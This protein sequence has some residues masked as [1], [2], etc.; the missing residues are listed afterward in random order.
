MAT[1]TTRRFGR[2]RDSGMIASERARDVDALA[3]V[4]REAPRQLALEL[5]LLAQQREG[6]VLLIID[7]LEELF[8]LVDDPDEQRKFVEAMCS[9]ADDPSEPVRVIFTLRDDF[10][11]KL[12]SMGPA[13]REVLRHA[14]VLQS[15]PKE[16]LE[17]ILTRPVEAVGY[18]YDDKTL[19]NEMVSSVDDAASLPL[20][21]FAARTLWDK[22]NKVSRTLRRKD[23]DEMGG[24]AGALAKHAEEVLEGLTVT[25][26][27][28]ARTL[29]LRLVTPSGTRRIISESRLVDGLSDEVTEVLS[30]LTHSRLISVGK[31]KEDPDSEVIVEETGAT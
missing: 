13:G 12:A 15:P 19:P 29:L 2:T 10:L 24:V 28:V 21:Q 27:K 25:E 20:L 23:Y 5:Q 7:Q 8:T 17:E 30:R 16:A 26:L 6:K 1:E 9:A 11:G 3:E 14:F 22:R 18:R 4:I 31:S